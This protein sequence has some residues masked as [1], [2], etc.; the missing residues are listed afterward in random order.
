M[1]SFMTVMRYGSQI[2]PLVHPTTLAGRFGTPFF[3][4][5][6]QATT[7][8]THEGRSLTVCR[9]NAVGRSPQCIPNALDS[10]RPLTRA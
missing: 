6:I 4:I 1:K 7:Q 3:P 10:E 8:L 5:K 2:Y 9:R